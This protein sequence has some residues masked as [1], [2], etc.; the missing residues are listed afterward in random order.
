MQK[1]LTVLGAGGSIEFGMPSVDDIDELFKEWSRIDYP[2]IGSWPNSLYTW[3]KE[4]LVNEGNTKLYF[5]NYLHAI[6]IISSR[7][8]GSYP[9]EGIYCSILI[10]DFP[11]IRSEYSAVHVASQNDFDKLNTFLNNKLLNHIR[12]KCLHLDSDR[13]AELKEMRQFFTFLKANY[14]LGFI[15]LNY[16]NVLLTAIPN[17]NTGFSN[18]NTQFELGE[19]YSDKWDFCYHIHGSVHFDMATGEQIT[20]NPDLNSK[21]GVGA[22]NRRR[23]TTSEGRKHPM[24][25]IIT[26]FDKI[27]QIYRE[28]L[29]Q[30]FFKIDQR[31]YESDA[32]L[33]IGYGFN[34]SYINEVIRAHSKDKGKKRNIVVI[35][36]KEKM[37]SLSEGGDDWGS[38]LLYTAATP[39]YQM[40]NGCTNLRYR[41]DN[42]AEYR[43]T[44][45]FEFSDNPD[46]PLYVWYSG[47]LEACR[48]KEKIIK[49]LEGHFIIPNGS[50]SSGT[51]GYRSANPNLT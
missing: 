16:D 34:D 44:Q 49:A 26:G 40:G 32:I 42:V 23:H 35:D 38:R 36:Y 33:F 37:R 9:I 21:F 51:K 11:K 3:V 20:W 10:D 50:I 27:N 45:T 13:H 15:N 14:E 12:K 8:K 19:I 2:I 48:N 25:T 39:N 41:P 28:P 1:L 24:S 43:R 30:Y 29:M 6:Q 5:E 46:N 4:K 31:I 7:G 17:L 47:F 18:E 22:P